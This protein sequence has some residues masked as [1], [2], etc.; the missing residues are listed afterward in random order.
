M[1]PQQEKRDA[2]GEPRPG[3]EEPERSWHRDSATDL[4]TVLFEQVRGYVSAPHRKK[5]PAKGCFP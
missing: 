3:G 1:V 4:E 5:L 2:G